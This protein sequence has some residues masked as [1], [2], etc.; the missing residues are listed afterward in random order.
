ML[1]FYD[2]P[3]N[4]RELQNF[5]HRAVILSPGSMLNLPLEEL[6]KPLSLGSDST[7]TANSRIASLEE[8][9]RE[10]IRHV[11]VQTR[12]RVGGRNGAAA[13]LGLNRTTLQSK[14]QR[15]GLSENSKLKK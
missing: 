5:I 7:T 9:E 8:V 10:H 12:W 3:G 2:W 4:I 11:L 13:L 14:I 6:R 15:L 1:Q